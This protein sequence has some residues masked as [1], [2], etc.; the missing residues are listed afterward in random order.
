[1]GPSRTHDEGSE[2]I[3][4]VDAPE[5]LASGV[6]QTAV[7]SA[8]RL[9]R[10]AAV[11]GQRDG[12]AAAGVTASRLI[13]TLA[14]LWSDARI[15]GWNAQDT[16]VWGT[17]RIPVE[18]LPSGF[19]GDDP[20]QPYTNES[21]RKRAIV[22]I[23]ENADLSSGKVEVLLHFHGRNIGYRERAAEGTV[24]D[25]EADMIE[26]Q[27]AG[28][29]RN[30]VAVLPQG[31]LQGDAQMTKFGIGDPTT[32]VNDVLEL[33]LPHLPANRQPTD[34]KLEASRLVV[35]GHSGGGPYAAAYANYAQQPS[36]TEQ[37]W[38]DAPP[39]LLF[40]GINGP[41]ELQQLEQWLDAWLRED[42]RW[43]TAAAD[44]SA[45]LDRRGL[46]FRSTW[47]TGSDPVYKRMNES[48]H[49]WLT[50]WFKNNSALASVAAKWRSQYRI[51]QFAGQH[52]YQV[53]T[54]QPAKPSERTGAPSGV[55]GRASG[56][57]GAPTYGGG[58]N[59]E[60]ALR[61]LR[62]NWVPGVISRTPRGVSPLGRGAA[63]VTRSDVSGLQ[64]AAGNRAVGRVL[65]RQATV[66]SISLETPTPLRADEAGQWLPPTVVYKPRRFRRNPAPDPLTDWS[67]FIPAAWIAKFNFSDPTA[68]PAVDVH[69][70]F[71]AG[72]STTNDFNDV[73]LHGL[74]GASNTTDWITIAVPGT[75]VNGQ[76][77]ATPF[78]DGDLTDALSS[79][80]IQSPVTSLRLSGHSRGAVSLVSYVSTMKAFKG[81]VDR[82]TLLDEFQFTDKAGVYHGKV[83]AIV[84]AGI[85]PSKIRGYETQNPASKHISGVEY[86]TLGPQD[87]A[88]IGSVRLIQDRIALDPA[89]A[90]AAASTNT[91]PDPQTKQMRTVKDEVD[92]LALPVRGTV[93][94][95]SAAASD[96]LQ[97][98]I[99]ANRAKLNAIST[100]HLLSFIN[101]KNLTRYPGQNWAPFA[102]HEFFVNEVAHELYN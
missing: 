9:S 102:G 23:P 41:G 29:A 51:Q 84:A 18:E 67:I 94:T 8:R 44:P 52:D 101:A 65:G 19:T 22:V 91:T 48:L 76:N 43:L 34:G 74:R 64:R 55:T 100:N 95:T 2:G 98:W 20:Q 93:Q 46:K 87:M 68:L 10:L 50:T 4:T 69:V 75:V 86:I 53:G 88:T 42:L 96:S 92:S 90:T 30:I 73:L 25:V 13:R 26:Q 45:L 1:V 24:R 15:G 66:S 37:E 38:V 97:S 7:T 72:A 78:T 6:R 56:A 33:A 63:A 83:E 89:I 82:V 36:S 54:G 16:N 81:V 71:G 31:R 59:L 27:L 80:G 11:A 17:L 60:S 47:G 62:S 49:T 79:I 3:Q 5:R 70:F 99:A 21:A 14:R 77:A 32:Y 40:D 28:S 12:R 61:E 39:L 58:G 85:T 57:A 35:S